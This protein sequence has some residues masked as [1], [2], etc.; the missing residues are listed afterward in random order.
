MATVVLV[1]SL[2]DVAALPLELTISIL[3]VAL[4]LS[5]VLVTDPHARNCAFILLLAPFS[6]PVLHAVEELTSVAVTV[7]PLVLSEAIRV[8]VAVL[9]YVLVSV[10]EEVRAVPMA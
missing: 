8:A 1:L 6:L 2:V 4:V 5:L 7:S 3:L 9:T 10:S